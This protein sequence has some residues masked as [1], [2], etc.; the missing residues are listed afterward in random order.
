MKVMKK[1][2]CWE[3][4]KCGR[5]FGGEK[6]KEFGVCPA[7][8]EKKT[9]GVNGGNFAGRCCWAIAGTLCGGQVQGI[10]ASKLSNCMKC[11]FYKQV[12]MEE[13]KALASTHEVLAMVSK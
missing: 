9:Q 8:T 7:S 12:N 1:Q 4:K 13:G 11:D 5:Q 10:F 6:S 2:N 3:I